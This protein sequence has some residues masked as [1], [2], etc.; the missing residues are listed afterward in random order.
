MV[1]QF[2]DLASAPLFIH[3]IFVAVSVIGLWIGSEWAV[4]GARG[5][6]IQLG[7]SELII[8]LTI[9]SIIS[10]LPEIAVN[11]SAALAGFDDVAAGNVVGSCF[12]Q[13][14]FILGLCVLI[15]GGI[16]RQRSGIPRDGLVLIGA[17]VAFIVLAFD[18]SISF[19]EGSSLILAYAI[20]LVIIVWQ[21]M[22]E[23]ALASN[24]RLTDQTEANGFSKLAVRSV[25]II[26]GS[27]VIWIMADVLV[28][29][30]TNAGERIGVSEGMIGLWT[31]V[32]TSIPELAISI[33]AALRGASGLSIGNLAGSN[34]TDPLLSLGIGAVVANGLSVSEFIAITAAGV[35]LAATLFAVAV[36]WFTGGLSRLSAI[37]MLSFYLM[38]QYLFVLG[39]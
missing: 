20:Y 17:N 39:S 8:G 29:V 2:V 24:G 13:I 3:G 6:A 4:S 12:V 28:E 25:Q 19:I 30:G 38:S 16:T 23:R 9:M 32:G 27:A 7:M 18:G 11:I 22:N 34:I 15:S 14:S 36:A 5:L 35:W 31:G 10:S 26:G 1:G 21:A 33:L 37:V